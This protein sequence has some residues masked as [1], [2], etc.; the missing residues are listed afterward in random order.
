MNMKISNKEMNIEIIY[1][2]EHSEFIKSCK[3]KFKKLFKLFSLLHYRND[4]SEI[5]IKLIKDDEMQEL[6]KLFYKRKKITDVLSFSEN[7]NE[8]FSG[9]IAIAES[10]IIS[11]KQPSPQKFFM[12]LI[13]GMLH[14]FGYDHGNKT[15]RENM[16]RLENTLM[17]NIDLQPSH[18]L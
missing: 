5:S 9:D 17:K 4:K 6:C 11:K 15:A 3:L 8:N 1:E 10:Y 13:H 16:R 14:L 12:L 7:I 2:K 18:E